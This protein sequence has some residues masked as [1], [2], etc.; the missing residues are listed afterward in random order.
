[1]S[2]WASLA[3]SIRD[4]RSSNAP[5]N[6]TTSGPPAGSSGPGASVARQGRR[7]SPTRDAVVG[8][9]AIE[10]IEA[11]A[12][13]DMLGTDPVPVGAKVDESLEI[14]HRQT[15]IEADLPG[16]N[17]PR[18]LQPLDVRADL[19]DLKPDSLRDRRPCLLQASTGSA[20]PRR[21]RAGARERR[22]HP[23]GTAARGPFR[24]NGAWPHPSPTAPWVSD[25]RNRNSARPNAI[26]AATATA[27]ATGAP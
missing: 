6:R 10:K 9:L 4:R 5:R 3:A 20:G 21:R 16:E 2:S 1:M 18:F 19:L 27:D 26:R 17:G 25:P 15:G 8:D 13:P 14:G 12:L 24:R 23:I 22:V 7:K 11:G